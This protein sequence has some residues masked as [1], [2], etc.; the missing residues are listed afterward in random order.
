MSHSTRHIVLGR[1]C[2]SFI[3]SSNHAIFVPL[4]ECVPVCSLITGEELL[5]SKYI[6]YIFQFQVQREQ[7]SPKRSTVVPYSWHGWRERERSLL[8]RVRQHHLTAPLARARYPDPPPRLGSKDERDGFWESVSQTAS[9]R[10]RS[11]SSASSPLFFRVGGSTV[12]NGRTVVPCACVRPDEASVTLP[13]TIPLSSPIVVLTMLPAQVRRAS[14]GHQERP[15][16]GA[17]GGGRRWRWSWR[18]RGKRQR[19]QRHLPKRHS[20][21][22]RASANKARGD[23]G[24]AYVCGVRRDCTPRV[25]EKG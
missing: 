4:G 8:K 23:Y 3:S 21:R 5:L 17:G 14:E 20:G 24:G 10:E 12:G 7:N 6:R 25:P 2:C 13:P 15:P 16:P 9:G 1:S 18:A 22:D 11:P 19:R